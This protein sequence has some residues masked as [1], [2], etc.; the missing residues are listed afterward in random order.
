MMAF[1]AFAHDGSNA[2]LGDSANRLNPRRG[3]VAVIDG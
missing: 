2:R 3:R 1:S